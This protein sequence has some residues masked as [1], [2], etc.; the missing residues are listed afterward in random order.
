MKMKVP[1]IFKSKSSNS[2]P[3]SNSKSSSSS[4]SSSSGIS[5]VANSRLT[6]SKS[7]PERRKGVP[8]LISSKSA[9]PL[10]S[11]FKQRDKCDDTCSPSS[12]EVGSITDKSSE[13]S[14]EIKEL[15]TVFRIF[16]TNGD[17]KISVAELGAVLN[18]LGD[19]P[20]EEDL[21]LMVKEADSD[22]DGFIDLKEFVKLNTDTALEKTKPQEL[23][24]AFCVFDI[25]NDGLI[26]AE[27]LYR[28]LSRLG[29]K[30]LTMEECCRMI[31][32]VDSNGDGFVSYEEFEM[33]M[34][35]P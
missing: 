6:P 25:N 18:S 24:A 13:H 21:R 34:K 20:T 33:M 8:K 11:R 1:T 19:N 3:N 7:L 14:A 23:K 17:G 5:P 32:G 2:S 28:V 10:R 27:E 22:G 15:C 12:D 9:P 31:A 35:S 30:G 29:E 4:H 26:S 16:D